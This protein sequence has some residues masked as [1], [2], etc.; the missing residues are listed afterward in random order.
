MVS[1][2]NFHLEFVILLL[3]WPFEVQSLYDCYTSPETINNGNPIK[4]EEPFFM[5]C[6]VSN[7]FFGRNW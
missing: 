4:V 3:F 7:D 6:E 2:K 1:I 5:G